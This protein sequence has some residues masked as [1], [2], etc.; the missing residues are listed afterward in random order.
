[1][2]QHWLE[3]IMLRI[4]MDIVSALFCGLRLP[5]DDVLLAGSH[6]LA[7]QLYPLLLPIARDVAQKLETRV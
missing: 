4:D 1:M 3:F 5:R 7:D 2:N 6:R